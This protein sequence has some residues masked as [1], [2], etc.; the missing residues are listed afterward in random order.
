MIAQRRIRRELEETKDCFDALTENTSFAIL[1]EHSNIQYASDD[2]LDGVEYREP[3]VFVELL[4]FAR[5][6]LAEGG[7]C[8][9]TVCRTASGDVIHAEVAGLPIVCDGEW[10]LLAVVRPQADS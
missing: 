3:V 1:D 4:E 5:E 2:V 9:E 7:G 10:H 6:V 8:Y